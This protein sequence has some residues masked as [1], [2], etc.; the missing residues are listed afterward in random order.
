MYQVRL[1]AGKIAPGEIRTQ[2]TRIARGNYVHSAFSKYGS[3][4]IPAM[5]GDLLGIYIP[6]LNQIKALAPCR[7]R[8]RQMILLLNQ[9][10]Q[11]RRRY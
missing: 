5:R 4:P 7:H 9:L 11:S 1:D 2:T 3:L 6:S 10:R 8:H